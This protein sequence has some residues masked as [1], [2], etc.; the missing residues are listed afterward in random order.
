MCQLYCCRLQGWLR[1]RVAGCRVRCAS[2]TCCRLKDAIAT[3]EAF[4]KVGM[5]VRVRVRVGVRARLSPKPTR[6]P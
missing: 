6:N 4:V 1:L 2:S 5:R 3:L